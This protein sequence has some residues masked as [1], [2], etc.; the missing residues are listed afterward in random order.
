MNTPD[1]LGR[2]RTNLS[3]PD[4]ELRVGWSLQS[5]SHEKLEQG[6]RLIR[7][8]SSDSP[9]GCPTSATGT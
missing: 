1:T 4:A 3:K 2:F 5:Q 7:G 6:H 8:L 9:P